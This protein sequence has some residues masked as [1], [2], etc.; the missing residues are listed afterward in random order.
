MFE[1]VLSRNL[2]RGVGSTA[3]VRRSLRQSSL[4]L[5]GNSDLTGDTLRA[6]IDRTL[7]RR[8]RIT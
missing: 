8:R 5:G 4:R 6:D 7:L 2:R 1:R 3:L